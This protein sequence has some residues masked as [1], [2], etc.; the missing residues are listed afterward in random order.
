MKNPERVGRK[1]SSKGT[2]GS[3]SSAG[4][5]G[6]TGHS[7]GSKLAGKVDVQIK[8]GKVCNL[9]GPTVLTIFLF[10]KR[11]VKVLHIYIIQ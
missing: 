8:E 9:E 7:W 4:Q 10:C 2:R 6:V 1:N 11:F 3:P 5:P